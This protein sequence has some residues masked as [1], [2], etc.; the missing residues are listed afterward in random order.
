MGLIFSGDLKTFHLVSLNLLWSISSFW[1][2]MFAKKDGR[3]QEG[4]KHT[5][6]HPK[7]LKCCVFPSL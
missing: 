4:N 7:P 1:F 6:A 5:Q 2:I 3:D